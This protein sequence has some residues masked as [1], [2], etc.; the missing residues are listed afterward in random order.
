MKNQLFDNQPH[1]TYRQFYWKRALWLLGIPWGLQTGFIFVII[2]D[3]Q[4]VEYFLQW[5][6]ILQLLSFLLGG[7]LFA[8]TGGKALWKR[9]AANIKNSE[10]SN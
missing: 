5:E 4:V 8:W 3:K 9:S 1:G 10:L 2:Q 7:F 6:T